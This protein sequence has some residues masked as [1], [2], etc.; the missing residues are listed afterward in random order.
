MCYSKLEYS[1]DWNNFRHLKP[2]IADRLQNYRCH[3]IA[4]RKCRTSTSRSWFCSFWKIMLLSCFLLTEVGVINLEMPIQ[5]CV[6]FLN[7]YDVL[8]ALLSDWTSSVVVLQSHSGARSTSV[9]RRV[10]LDYWLPPFEG[11]EQIIY[12]PKASESADFRVACWISVQGM[13]KIKAD[14][15]SH[16]TESNDSCIGAVQHNGSMLCSALIL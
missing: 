4:F 1:Y 9:C 6:L 16:M 13:G 11:W 2:G 12:R 10:E 8:A 5:F 7:H 3:Q 14:L 15:I